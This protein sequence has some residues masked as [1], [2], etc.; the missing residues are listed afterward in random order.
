M[1]QGKV[2]IASHRSL[3]QSWERSS[4]SREILKGVVCEVTDRR[5]GEQW[6]SLPDSTR[7]S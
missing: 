5:P 7:L 1:S 2:L 6:K 4:L 3:D